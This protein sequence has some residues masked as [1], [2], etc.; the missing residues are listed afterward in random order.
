MVRAGTNHFQ[1]LGLDLPI[2]GTW[3]IDVTV[4]LDAFTEETGSTTF[5]LR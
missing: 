1:A 3:R 4:K 2:K 5:T